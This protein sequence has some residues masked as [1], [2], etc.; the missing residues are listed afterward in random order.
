MSERFLNLWQVPNHGRFANEVFH[1]FFASLLADKHRLNLRT[2][3]WVGNRL[4]EMHDSAIEQLAATIEDHDP[5]PEASPLWQ[6]L[7]G[8]PPPLNVC[9][10]GNFQYHTGL[11]TPEER[12][13][14]CAWFAPAGEILVPLQAELTAKMQGYKTLVAIHVRRGDY[15]QYCPWMF[16]RTPVESYLA[17]LASVWPHLPNP[18]L[19]VA[20]DDPE[21]TKSFSNYPIMPN[22]TSAPD[23]YGDFWALTQADAMAISNS[24]F[25]FAASMLNNHYN[26]SKPVYFM[27]PL[28]NGTMQSFNPWNDDV[29]L[30]RYDGPLVM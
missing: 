20:S 2:P 3:P 14:F 19:Y 8:G 17:W 27:R 11:Y 29:L 24:S 26:E 9:I 25:G 1:Y 22:L 5:R 12:E 16:Y 18:V 7:R 23:P 13:K 10:R 4:F 28:R 6:S 15:G 30:G 21:T